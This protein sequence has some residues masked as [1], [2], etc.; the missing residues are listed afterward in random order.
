MFAI[1]VANRKNVLDTSSAIDT[2]SMATA[3]VGAGGQANSR[4][5]TDHSFA[6]RTGTAISPPVTCTPCVN[7]Y[8]HD[9]PSASRRARRTAGR[10]RTSAVA[11]EVGLVGEVG[12]EAGQR[13]GR[14]EH[15]QHA[16]RAPT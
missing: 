12:Q 11:A 13:H 10:G 2:R 9:G 3:G 6:S 7:A 5:I 8:S 14:D 15:E 1:P 16:C 4:G